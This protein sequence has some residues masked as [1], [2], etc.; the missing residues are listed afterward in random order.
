MNTQFSL[1]QQEIPTSSYPLDKLPAFDSRTAR[2]SILVVDDEP[3]IADTLSAILTEHGFIAHKAYNPG[4]ALRLAESA[5]PDIV[6]SDV[7]M[8][9]MSGIDMCIRIRDLLPQTRIVLLS[10]QAGTAELIHRAASKGH[11]FELLPKPIH[12]EDLVA[13]LKQISK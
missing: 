8:P 7:L 5:R 10:G 9:K 12:P 13:R 11:E 3:V 6:L 2:P 1:G 4:D